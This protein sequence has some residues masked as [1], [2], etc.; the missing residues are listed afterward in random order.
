MIDAIVSKN[1]LKN[2]T[3]HCTQSWTQ[4]P[5]E[6]LSAI[7]SWLANIHDQ[8]IT[9]AL[10]LHTAEQLAKMR[11]HPIAQQKLQEF[12]KSKNT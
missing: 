11:T 9:E 3:E 6:T 4:L 12:L 2:Y 1:E 10:Q 8:P 5:A 7:K